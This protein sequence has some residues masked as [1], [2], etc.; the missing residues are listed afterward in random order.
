L[1]ILLDSLDKDDLAE[2]EA[3]WL[4]T[5]HLCCLY[6]NIHRGKGQKPYKVE[7]FMPILGGKPKQKQPQTWHDHLRILE[8]LTVL[9]GGED[10]R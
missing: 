4:H 3:A 8:M 10:M 1:D 7:D 9:H 6:A 2:L 5:A